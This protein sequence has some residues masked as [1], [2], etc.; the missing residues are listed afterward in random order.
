[1]HLS[2]MR[3][4]DREMTLRFEGRFGW[5][6][7]A[8]ASSFMGGKIEF[9]GAEI[10]CQKVYGFSAFHGQSLSEH[11]GRIYH[12]ARMRL[13]QPENGDYLRSMTADRVRWNSIG[14]GGYSRKA[15]GGSGIGLGGSSTGGRCG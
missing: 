9:Y 6:V 12:A 1:M 4:T 5:A 2:S 15:T 7:G 3:G 8:P 11:V 14:N 13:P 10:I